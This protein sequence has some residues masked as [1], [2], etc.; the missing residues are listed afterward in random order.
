MDSFSLHPRLEADSIFVRDLYLSQ[1]R[2]SNVKASPWLILVPRRANI[3]EIF[4]LEKNDRMQLMEEIAQTS[5]ALSGLY[6]P[7][8]I[9]VAALGNQVAQL[10]VHIIA[11]FTGDAAWPDPI[12]SRIPMD[13]YEIGAAGLIKA[14]LNDGK[15]WA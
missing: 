14:K 9:N 11:R 5:K 8:K 4:E 15:F 3:R 10:H 13:P 12:W 2:L 6:A 1:L 7:D